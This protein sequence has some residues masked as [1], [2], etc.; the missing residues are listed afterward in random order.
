MGGGRRWRS[1]IR[2]PRCVSLKCE[3]SW[4]RAGGDMDTAQVVKG[5]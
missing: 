1:D 2:M 3:V 4:V 5:A